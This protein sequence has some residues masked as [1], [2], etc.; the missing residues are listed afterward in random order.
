MMKPSSLML[1]LCLLVPQFD[2]ADSPSIAEKYGQTAQK[3][4]DAALADH[5]STAR[6]ELSVRSHR[7]SAQQVGLSGAGH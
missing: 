3:R 5:R 6:L 1:G 2:A 4:I 7:Q